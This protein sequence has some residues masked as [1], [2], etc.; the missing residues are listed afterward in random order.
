MG[1]WCKWWSGGWRPW[2]NSFHYPQSYEAR[3]NVKAAC[4]LCDCFTPK[5]LSPGH[6]WHHLYLSTL[7]IFTAQ[8][9]H[10]PTHY[11]FI[12]TS[13]CISQLST[14]WQLIKASKGWHITYNNTIIYTNESYKWRLNVLH[15]ATN[16]GT[17]PN[18]PST[19]SYYQIL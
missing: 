7:K 19:T 2:P 8:H 1:S 15:Y 16:Q 12:P 9:H 13:M 4:G 17:N 10:H 3:P 18:S 5:R 6:G 14:T 11:S